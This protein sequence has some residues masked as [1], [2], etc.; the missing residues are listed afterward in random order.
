MF[1][2]S[3]SVFFQMGNRSVPAVKSLGFGTPAGGEAL[4]HPPVLLLRAGGGVAPGP[5]HQNQQQGEGPPQQHLH[6]I[7]CS[8]LK[9]WQVCYIKIRKNIIHRMRETVGEKI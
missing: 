5:A 7:G 1:C 4:L 6:W 2:L 8:C 9:N 3:I